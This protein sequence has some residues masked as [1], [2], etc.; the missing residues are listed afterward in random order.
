MLRSFNFYLIAFFFIS[1]S[2]SIHAQVGALQKDFGNAGYVDINLLD[3]VHAGNLY[4]FIIK[5]DILEN[6]Y[7]A[8]VYDSR[9]LAVEKI[10]PDGKPDL[11]FGNKGRL[12]II[13]GL[14]DEN[15]QYV[16]LMQIDSEENIYL[17]TNSTNNT[18][19]TISKYNRFGKIDLSFGTKGKLILNGNYASDF[20]KDDT[21]FYVSTTTNVIK[22]DKNGAFDTSFGANGIASPPFN[23]LYV[24]NVISNIQLNSEGYIYLSVQYANYASLM[25][26]DP[27]GA[28]VTTFGTN[29]VVTLPDLWTSKHMVLDNQERV[30][31]HHDNATSTVNGITINTLYRYLPSG[32]PDLTYGT[33]GVF[34]IS[35]PSYSSTTLND[36]KIDASNNIYLSG[37]GRTSSTYYESLIIKINAAGTGYDASFNSDGI[38]NFIYEGLNSTDYLFINKNGTLSSGGFIDQGAGKMLAKTVSINSSGTI[39]NSFSTAF[40][41]INSSDNASHGI[42][43]QQGNLFVLGYLTNSYPVLTSMSTEGNLRPAFGDNGKKIYTPETFSLN[44]ILME[45]NGNIYSAGGS[46]NSTDQSLNR[47]AVTKTDKHG[48]LITS[49][50]V[51][52]ILT[53][54]SD[55]TFTNVFELLFDQDSSL[56]VFSNSI[57]STSILITKITRSGNIDLSYGNQGSLVIS[58]STSIYGNKAIIDNAGIIYISGKASTTDFFVTKISN[59]IIDPLFGINGFVIRSLPNLYPTYP[60]CS[61]MDFDSNGNIVV[62]GW[63]GSGLNPGPQALL[64]KLSHTT[65]E[66]IPE[67]G[68]SGFITLPTI[69]FAVYDLI[70]DENDNIFLFGNTSPYGNTFAVAKTN[71]L[72]QIDASYGNNGLAI[73]A[74]GWYDGV[75]YDKKRGVA[76]LYGAINSDVRIVSIQIEKPNFN[77]ITGTVFKDADASCDKGQ[78]ESG[79]NNMNIVAQPGYNYSITDA[80]GSYVLKVDTGTYQYTVKQILNPIQQQL[81]L[82]T[83]TDSY[84]VPLTGSEKTISNIDFSDKLNPQTCPLLYIDIQNTVRRRCYNGITKI[85]YANYGTASESNVIIKITYP[86]QI[87]IKQSTP[88]WQSMSANVLTYNIGLLNAG[89]EGYITIADSVLCLSESVIGLTQCVKAEISPVRNCVVPPIWDRSEIKI[90]QICRSDSSVFFI[91]NIGTG[92]MNAPRNFNVF[93]NDTI[94]YSSTFLLESNAALSVS[95]PANGKSIRVDAEQ[96]PDFPF[97]SNPSLTTQSCNATTI[98]NPVRTPLTNLPLD[99]RSFYTAYSCL[100]IIGSFDPNHKSV[101]PS[102]YGTEHYI[103]KKDKLTYMIQFQN[104]GTDTAFK[105]VVIDTLDNDL[106]IETLLVES[107]SHAY[108][109]TLSGR[110]TPVLKFSFDPIVLTDSTSNLIKSQGFISYSIYPKEDVSEGTILSNKAYIFFDYNNPI[111]TNETILTI[112]NDYL[113]DLSKGSAVAVRTGLVTANKNPVAKNILVYPN[114]AKDQLHIKSTSLNLKSIQF[115]S[116]TGSIVLTEKLSGN[117]FSIKINTLTPGIYFYT[118]LDESENSLQGKI[119]VE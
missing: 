3:T 109:Y 104:V 6:T 22:F 46:F 110:G 37:N 87:K 40:N 53:Y 20:I 2:N 1:F 74:A 34:N 90:S 29:G 102:G 71:A 118:I 9:I 84:N 59:Q 88:A 4:P 93:V 5:K 107:S 47:N 57:N 60:T 36:M 68:S 38:M 72:G 103:N 77:T 100:P 18:F 64:F 76:Y 15:F 48:N 33:N 24:N 115:I 98:A 83:C 81:Y 35:I 50:G 51:N 91:Q 69:N 95:Y 42:L 45:K 116:I 21:Y 41:N 39:T 99:D 70:L 86:D 31:V 12:E 92:D 101:T 56:L 89:Q 114:P 44:R 73:V 119:I 65:G 117:D 28:L 7:I 78:S 26:L 43:D 113:Q 96:H 80:S 63:Y 85:K 14:K 111:L 30:L 10:A 17:I 82:N 13:T 67:F 66:A 94:I 23:Q 61:A 25:K 32:L 16:L 58:T 106:N 49:F 75:V 97:P 27:S 54:Q 52:G 8:G 62:S 112:K 11:L 55:V 79:I 108:T 19:F 105:V